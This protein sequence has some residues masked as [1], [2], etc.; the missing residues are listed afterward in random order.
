MQFRDLQ[1]EDVAKLLAFELANRAWFEKTV[2][3]RHEAFYTTEGVA[4]HIR[5]CLDGYA[6]GILHPLVIL[7]ADGD[8]AG[9]A[10]LR[11][12]DPA[13]GCC[14]IGYRI[15]EPHCGKG[16]ASASVR[17]MQQLAY[18][19]WRLAFLQA[20]ASIENPASARVLEKNG[21]VR[22]ELVR[23][24]SLVQGRRLDSYRYRHVPA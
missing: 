10:N 23:E 21:F 15:A 1:I 12:I 5:E 3:G 20:Y 24:R 7:D 17:Y 4:A 8:I 19:T 2:E 16:W 18:G 11:F 6:C 13:A 9:R 14:E 22:Q